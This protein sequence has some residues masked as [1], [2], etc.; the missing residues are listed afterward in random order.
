MKRIRV[1]LL[2]ALLSVFFSTCA[3]AAIEDE[4]DT[5]SIVDA[6]PSAAQEIMD[7]YSPL[8]TDTDGALSR[9]GNYI[10]QK[11]G[12]VWRE[13]CG[14][15]IK[16]IAVVLICSIV[17]GLNLFSGGFDYVNLAGCLAIAVLTVSDVNSFVKLGSEMLEEI[18]IF[19]KVL[20]PTLATAATAAG[21]ATSASI[22]YA[23]TAMF[24]DLLISVANA[25]IFPMICA[26][27]ACVVASSAIGDKR[28]DAVV[29]LLKKVTML[30]MTALVAVFTAYLSI[31][32]VIASSTDAATVKLAKTAISAVLPVVGR[33]I[34]DAAGTIIAGAG[35]IRSCIGVFGLIAVLATCALPFLRLGLRYLLFKAAAA[36]TEP[37]SG[38]RIGSLIDGIGTVYG[39]ILS[40]AGIG[41]IFI[42]F[43]I[44]SLI[45]VVGG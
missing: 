26:Y 27:T 25:V 31:T 34:S 17:S 14:S 2:I 29:K 36:L 5:G 44:I 28:I 16:I 10:K 13:T 40:A 42:F 45:K 12:D 32:G 8:D 43:G 18:S 7:G 9:L 24:M 1:L 4:L 23:G 39:M 19:S 41:G 21:A 22:K 11:L 20:L 37:M 38:D 6:L 35:I 15:V 33:T 3:Q 30:S